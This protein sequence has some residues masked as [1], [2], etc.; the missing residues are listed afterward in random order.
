M[1]ATTAD[2]L[3]AQ[4]ITAPVISASPTVFAGMLDAQLAERAK[5]IHELRMGLRA[6][7]RQAVGAVR[8][9]LLEVTGRDDLE[10]LAARYRRPA[11]VPLRYAK[12]C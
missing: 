10:Q 7:A 6:G 11:D 3:A 8:T 2:Q 9:D 12:R 4:A 5:A 1:N